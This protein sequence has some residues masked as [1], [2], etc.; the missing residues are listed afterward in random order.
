[1][2]IGTLLRGVL[3]GGL[4]EQSLVHFL[5]DE[6]ATLGHLEQLDDA[7]DKY[8]GYGVCLTFIYQSLGQLKKCFPDGQDQTLLSNVTQV[9]FG[10]NDPQTADFDLALQSNSCLPSIVAYHALFVFRH[11][12][13]DMIPP[14]VGCNSP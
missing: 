13:L 9:F 14:P 12:G 11:H 6:A 8:R 7:V 10:V 4:Q 3:R 5:I 1:M 2:W